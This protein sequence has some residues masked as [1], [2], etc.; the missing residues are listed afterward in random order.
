MI[1]EKVLSVACILFLFVSLAWANGQGEGTASNESE[2][3]VLKLMD[4]SDSSKPYREALIED[5][6]QQNPNIKIEYT[7]LTMDQFK[8][9]VLTAITMGDAPDLFPLPDGMSLESAIK[10][11]WF[12]PL[13]SYLDDDFFNTFKIRFF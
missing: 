10:E 12:Q 1:K 7:C 5:F 6:E 8:N 9:T 3:I 11:E 4:W 2:T 13:N